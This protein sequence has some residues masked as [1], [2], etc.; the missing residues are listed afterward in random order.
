MLNRI[1]LVCVCEEWCNMKPEVANDCIRCPKGRGVTWKKGSAG[2]PRDPSTRAASFF[3][4]GAVFPRLFDHSQRLHIR[5]GN[6]CL[7]GQAAR[8]KCQWHGTA[9]CSR[10]SWVLSTPILLL[11]HPKWV[12]QEIALFVFGRCGQKPYNAGEPKEEPLCMRTILRHPRP[13]A[14]MRH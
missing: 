4:G 1:N 10:E 7:S 12:S 11:S 9:V 5:L 3:F 2:H 8:A 6:K 13:L 14:P